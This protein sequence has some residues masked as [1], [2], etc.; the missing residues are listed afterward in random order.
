MTTQ[1]QFG[2]QWTEE[3]LNRLRSYLPAYT[4]IFRANER[5]KLYTT[6][7]LDAFAG[8][9]Y[10]SGIES[11]AAIRT[12][13]VGLFD[14]D[15]DNITLDDADAESF[16]KG[17]ARI[18]LE[19]EPSFDHYIFVEQKLEHIRNLEMLRT[20]FPAKSHQIEIVQ[21]DA[22]IFLQRWCLEMNWHRNRA[23]VFLDPYGMSVEW[24]TIEALGKTKA[25]DLWIL[26][27][28]G[29]AVNRLLTR[30]QPPQ[31]PWARK[32]TAFFGT[33]DWKTAFY[34]PSRQPSLF[35]AGQAL[36]KEA[37][38]EGISEFFVQRLETA[39]AKV[40]KNALTLRNSRNVPIYLLYFAAANPKGAP[41]AVRIANHILGK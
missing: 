37:D 19:V 20:Q 16:S 2:G 26:F 5:A 29:Q 14:N 11:S 28:L 35:D 10:R 38:F 6:Y 41:T 1:H 32:L 23:V 27:P 21:S 36:R 18:A 25:V 33:E 17:S 30:A 3:K 7:Y 15:I 40:A 9:G 31:G 12:A 13:G 34:Q 22:N 8:T 39:F 4:R 24:K